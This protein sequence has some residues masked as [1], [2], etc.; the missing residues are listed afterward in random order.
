MPIFET[1]G[2]VATTAV[3]L[4]IRFKANQIVFVGLDMAYTGNR[5]HASGARDEGIT[6]YQDMIMVDGVYGDK[7]PTTQPFQMYRE[8]IERRIARADVNMPVVDAT[9]G[10]AKIKGTEV[11]MLR[12]VISAI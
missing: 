5:N 6:D 10:G 12:D 1:G 9:E 3:D 8:W 4:C 2:S 11:K 7:V